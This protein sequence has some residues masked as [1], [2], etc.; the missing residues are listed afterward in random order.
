MAGARELKK[1]PQG[2]GGG[3][4]AAAIA[5]LAAGA[6][7]AAYIGLCYWVGG[8][9]I[10]PNVSV[11]GIDLSGLSQAQAQELLS[12]WLEEQ[13]SQVEVELSYGSWSAQLDGAG[14]LPSSGSSAQAALAVGRENFFARGLAYLTHRLGESTQVDL[15]AQMT[16][17]GVRNLDRLLDEADR[18]VGGGV[19]GADYSL[20][21]DALVITK[22]VTGVAID[23]PQAREMVAQALG[24]AVEESLTAGQARR[25]VEL[26]AQEEAPRNPDFQEILSELS[27]EAQDAS[28]D[29][30][31]FEIKPHVV[32]VSFDWQAAQ[33]AY[34]R[35]EEGETVS[36]P[37]E[38]EQPAETTESLEGKLFADLLGEGTTQVSGSANRKHNVK[39]SAE[40][41]NGVI[42]MPGEEFS[43][44]N[45]TG[46]RSEA[47]GY[48]MAPIYGEGG[49][50]ED[51]VGGGICQ[52]S[53]T[54][55]Y[56]VLHTTLEIVERHAHMYATGY[57]KDGMDATVYF[58]SLDFRFRNNTNYPVKIVTESYDKNGKRFLT[59]K[60]YGTN[61]T[62]RY[63]VPERVQ[64][65]FV[66]PGVRYVADSSI[67]RGTTQK[68]TKQ[69]PYQG[70]KARTYRYIYEA[71]GTLAEKQD[72]GVSTYRMRPTTYRY[73]PLDGDPAAWVNGTPPSPE[74]EPPVQD[75]FTDPLIPITPEPEPEPVPEPEP[76]PEPEPVPEPEH[77]P[78][79]DLLP[80]QLP[81]GY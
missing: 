6:L 26:P 79:D 66:E 36:I 37:L 68:D 51:G 12:R 73:N 48:R 50:S 8:G 47:N 65:D 77:H 76:D 5:V 25:T 34:D 31:T 38:L 18:E 9:A 13:A 67:P 10:L 46:S 53:S 23:R 52:T 75:P 40:S 63:A 57:V 44:N 3:A 7:A 60:L 11:A 42:L 14:L 32:G 43:Y 45:T 49:V 62:G 61:E 56:A 16:E 70:R 64:F 22:G 27:V 81:D 17:E 54:I 78:N 35:A 41:C 72:L 80:G 20:T 55:Y 39:L 15:S 74:P 1:T 69:Y 58:G 30:E 59:V 4:L 19:T 33:A 28:I 71:D 2:T 24:E 29:P 21:E